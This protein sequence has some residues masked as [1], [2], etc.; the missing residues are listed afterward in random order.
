MRHYEAA[1]NAGE[2]AAASSL[3][4]M[5]LQGVGTEQDNATAIK[6]LEK[7]AESKHPI[8]LNGLGY[9]HLHGFGRDINYTEA[10]K[11]FFAQTNSFTPLPKVGRAENQNLGTRE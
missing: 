7:G 4:L 6:W 10:V 5:H 11:F 2:P 1:A 3:G 9:V 8:A